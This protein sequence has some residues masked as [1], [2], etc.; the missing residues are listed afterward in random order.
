MLG[1]R[2]LSDEEIQLVSQ[3]FFGK[4]ALRDRCLFELGIRS[5]FRIS[6]LLSLRVEDVLQYGR[7][8]DRITCQRR[9]MKGGHQSRSV[10]LH[11]KARAALQEWLQV[12]PGTTGPL[13][14]SRKGDKAIS[15]QQ[16]HTVLREA[17]RANE[18][19]GKVATHSMRKSFA[20]KVYEGSGRDLVRTAAALGHKSVGSTMS[21]LSFKESEIDDLVLST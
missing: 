13:F 17:F 7:L 16:A 14:P 18:L 20:N 6:E 1:C 12:L 8:T 21:Y 19:Q 15:R 2:P 3:S 5:G 11:S 10:I 9:S 4:Y